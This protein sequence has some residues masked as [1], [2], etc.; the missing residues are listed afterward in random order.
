MV[1]V[2]TTIFKKNLKDVYMHHPRNFKDLE[3]PE[4]AVGDFAT[5]HYFLGIKVT[6]KKRGI[7]PP[8]YANDLLK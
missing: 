2:N 1:L 7:G 3:H 4:F 5:L 8:K 6:Y